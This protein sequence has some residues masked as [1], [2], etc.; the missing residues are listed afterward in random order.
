MYPMNLLLYT[1]NRLSVVCGGCYWWHLTG[2][3]KNNQEKMTS[4]Q[5]RMKKIKTGPK[6]GD[7]QH[8]KKATVKENNNF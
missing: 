8:W 5:A 6:L 4:L 2:Y 7:L 1:K 3:Y